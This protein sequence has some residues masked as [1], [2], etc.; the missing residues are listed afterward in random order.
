[1]GKISCSNGTPLGQLTGAASRRRG[2]RLAC[3]RA[4]DLIAVLILWGPTTTRGRANQLAM[5][6]YDWRHERH[7]WVAAALRC[8]SHRWW[9]S[10]SRCR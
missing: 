2:S 7:S 8:A 5:I 10:P 6:R 9:W 4:P 3:R 1:M